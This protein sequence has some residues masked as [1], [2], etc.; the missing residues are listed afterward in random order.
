MSKLEVC[1]I[2]TGR[3]FKNQI[4]NVLYYLK[5]K[6]R[7]KISGICNKHGR[8]EQHIMT[9]LTVSK[10]YTNYKELLSNTN[11]KIV[12]LSLSSKRDGENLIY[13]IIDYLSTR[14]IFILTETQIFNKLNINILEKIKK[15]KCKVGVL[16]NWIYLPSQSVIKQIINSGI[17]GEI[18][19]VENGV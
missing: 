19:H 2:G 9:E 5:D 10:I 3:R 11:P 12:L 7:I 8:L 17:L 15:Y 18:Y 6:N 13:E 14:N 1:I 16:E 4:V